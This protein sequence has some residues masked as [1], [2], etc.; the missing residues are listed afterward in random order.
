MRWYKLC[1][2]TLK[3]FYINMLNKYT[4]P[5]FYDFEQRYETLVS[6]LL[7]RMIDN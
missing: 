1:F 2:A 5:F 4:C 6:H 7:S 3:Q